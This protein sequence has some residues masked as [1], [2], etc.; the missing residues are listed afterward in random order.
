MCFLLLF[1]VP[2]DPHGGPLGLELPVKHTPGSSLA[3][4][5]GLR[6]YIRSDFKPFDPSEAHSEMLLPQKKGGLPRRF[7]IFTILGQ[8]A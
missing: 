4:Y 6:A 3:M 7:T 1:D 8:I 2:T 5:S